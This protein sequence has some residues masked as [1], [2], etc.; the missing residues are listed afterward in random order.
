MNMDKVLDEDLQDVIPP[1][2]RGCLSLDQALLIQIIR[3]LKD[4]DVEE[5]S[6]AVRGFGL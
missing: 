2:G 5:K 3:L 6:P 4:D 1:V